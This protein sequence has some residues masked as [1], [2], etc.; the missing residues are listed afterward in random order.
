VRIYSLD[1]IISV[2]YQVNSKRGMQIWTSSHAFKRAFYLLSAG[3]N[4]AF[5]ASPILPAPMGAKIS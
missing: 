2:G 5:H 1:A 4:L 3:D